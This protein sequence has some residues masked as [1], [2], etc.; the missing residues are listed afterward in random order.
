MAS[1]V[2]QMVMARAARRGGILTIDDV[3]SLGVEDKV[4]SRLVAS[5]VFRRAFPGVFVLASRP[6]DH[7]L[8]LR[9]A[10]VAAGAGAVASHRSAAWVYG[11]I[12]RPPPDPEI[13]LVRSAH[14]RGEGMILHRSQVAV[15]SRRVRG[16]VCTEPLRTLVDLASQVGPGSDLTGALDRALAN[17]HISLVTLERSLPRRRRGVEAVRAYLAERGYVGGPAPSM[18]E[19][20]MARILAQAGLTGFNAEVIAGSAGQ[21]RIDFA[22]PGVRLALECYGYAWHS[23]PAQ[24]V[25]DERRH[26]ALTLEGWTVLIYT[27]HDLDGDPRRVVAEIREAYRRCAGGGAGAGRRRTG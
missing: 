7:R 3:R 26:R 15:S 18:L 24:L 6:Q 1:D 27:W 9:A 17:R 22:D 25:R 11:W 20:R 4:V 23:S 5:G 2:T 21:Y 8:L 10:M 13:T 19:S 14:R 16:V 12:D